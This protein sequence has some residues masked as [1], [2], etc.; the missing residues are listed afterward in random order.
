MSMLMR[1]YGSRGS[2]QKP[3]DEEFSLL[4]LLSGERTVWGADSPSI[5]KQLVDLGSFYQT[6]KRFEDSE[7]YFSS[8]E[9]NIQAGLGSDHPQLL[10]VLPQYAAMLREKGQLKEAEAKESAA[11]EI[12]K[13]FSIPEPKPRINPK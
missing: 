8:A 11:M 5:T 2:T 10:E 13:K 4:Q 9:K 3:A 6:Q 12:R 7:R 1:H